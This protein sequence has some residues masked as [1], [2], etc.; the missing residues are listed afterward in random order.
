MKLIKLLVWGCTVIIGTQV[1]AASIW[2][3][4]ANGRVMLSDTPCPTTGKLVD[5]RTLESNSLQAQPV[6]PVDP[7]LLA[8][9]VVTE[10]GNVCPS[11]LE[12]RN[13]ETQASSSSIGDAQRNFLNDEMRRARQCQ[14]GQGRYTAKDWQVSKDAREAQN[15]NAGGRAERERAEAMHSA[16]DPIEGD[17]IAKARQLD[18]VLRRQEEA[19]ARL[20]RI[21]IAR[22]TNNSCWDEMGARYELTARPGIYLGPRGECKRLDAVF[23]CS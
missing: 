17:R 5:S 6:K 10:Q 3:C 12:I 11:D 21:R 9:P 8:P 15:N 7:A 18:E 23:Q 19:Q 22:C 4:E 1:S 20:L 13:I 14:K 2:K 16:A